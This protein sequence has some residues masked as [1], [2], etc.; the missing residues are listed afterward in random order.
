MGKMALG[1]K[2][3]LIGMILGALGMTAVAAIPLVTGGDCDGLRGLVSEWAAELAAAQVRGAVRRD[4]IERRSVNLDSARQALAECET[5]NPYPLIA[6]AL[7]LG[8]AWSTIVV[9]HLRRRRL[10]NPRFKTL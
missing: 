6:V 4:Q 10:H 5:R 2:L 1:K 9:V 7:I 8:A 3:G